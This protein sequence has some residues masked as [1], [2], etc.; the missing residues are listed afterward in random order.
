LFRDLYRPDHFPECLLRPPPGFPYEIAYPEDLDP[1][2]KA[3]LVDLY[4]NNSGTF[5]DVFELLAAE[6]NQA[7]SPLLL[8]HHA[9]GNATACTGSAK[10][11]PDLFR[12]VSTIARKFPAPFDSHN[13]REQRSLEQILDSFQVTAPSSRSPH[14]VLRW[15][16]LS[17]ARAGRTPAG[18]STFRPFQ[19]QGAWPS[20][21]R[22][23]F[24]LAA[25]GQQPLLYEQTFQGPPRRRR[26]EPVDVYV[27]VS[28]SCGNFIPALYAA[29]ASCRHLVAPR[30]HVFSGVVKT[31]T[32]AQLQEGVVWAT[33]G[34]CGASVTDHIT[35]TKSRAAVVLTDGLVGAIPADHLTACRRA[36]LQVVLTPGGSRRDL[37]PVT[38][39]FHNLESP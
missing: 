6:L 32:M 16:L 37:A 11:D 27:D 23:A 5:A 33:G 10:S 1:R 24:A 21:D 14:R 7:E 26:L 15:A 38:T 3:A 12:V 18:P 31:V 8:G 9:D 35:T 4:E 25:A 22:R 36:R 19:G 34:T 20:R 39:A 28:P 13:S 17:A 30:V 29:V 2:W